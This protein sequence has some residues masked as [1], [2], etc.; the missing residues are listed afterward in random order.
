MPIEK[1]SKNLPRSFQMKTMNEEELLRLGA[2]QY[3]ISS[4]PTFSECMSKCLA[5]NASRINAYSY[6]R[7]TIC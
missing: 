4:Q 6:C 3:N 7:N 1:K 5:R 2:L